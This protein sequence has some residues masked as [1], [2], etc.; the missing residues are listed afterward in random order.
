MKQFRICVLAVNLKIC[1][2]LKHIIAKLLKFMSIPYNFSKTGMIIVARKKVI[3][4]SYVVMLEGNCNYSIL[5]LSSGKQILIARTLKYFE[6]S[7]LMQ[8]F[9]RVHRAFLVNSR[10]IKSYDKVELKLLLTDGLSIEVSRRR[11]CVLEESWS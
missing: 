7:L 6:E 1:Q 5:H 10:H 9:L 8:G 4:L 3:P 11:K 2:L